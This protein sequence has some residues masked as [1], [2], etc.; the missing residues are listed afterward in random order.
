[1]TPTR[2]LR[3]FLSPAEGGVAGRE[4]VRR[5]LTRIDPTPSWHTHY[6]PDLRPALYPFL[7]GYVLQRFA[8]QCSR[9]RALIVK[10]NFEEATKPLVEADTGLEMLKSRYLSATRSETDRADLRR[11]VR[12]WCRKVEEAQL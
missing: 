3:A 2:V 12:D 5:L 7:D 11:Q 10:G 6:P 8:D 4:R 1:N 9:P